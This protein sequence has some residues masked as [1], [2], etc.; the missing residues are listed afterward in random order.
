MRSMPSGRSATRTACSTAR[1]ARSTRLHAHDEHEVR[2]HERPRAHAVERRHQA[3]VEVLPE[4]HALRL[5]AAAVHHERVGVVASPRVA[6]AGYEVAV[7]P[8]PR[9]G[10]A[11]RP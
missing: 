4:P 7:L 3:D 9:W 1:A 6:D 5:V 10:R 11:R 2:T 8:D